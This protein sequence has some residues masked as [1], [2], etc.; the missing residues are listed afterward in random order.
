MR[1]V[2]GGGGLS[3]KV[4]IENHVRSM[5]AWVSYMGAKIVVCVVM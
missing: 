2:G 3:L 5:V 4:C 1:V